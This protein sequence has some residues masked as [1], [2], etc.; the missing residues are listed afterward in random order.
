MEFA[1]SSP[2]TELLNI[3]EGNKGELMPKGICISGTQAVP[4]VNKK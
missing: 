3:D 2:A 1:W 4:N